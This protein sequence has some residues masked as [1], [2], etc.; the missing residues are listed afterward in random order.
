[1]TEVGRW[2]ASESPKTRDT[3][4]SFSVQH[5]NKG[6]DGESSRCGEGRGGTEGAHVGR[7]SRDSEDGH[8]AEGHLKAEH[9]GSTHGEKW[10][11]ASAEGRRRGPEVVRAA[12]CWGAVS[13]RACVCDLL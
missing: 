11:P 9:G 5:L 4:R 13:H 8:A 6:D 7:S 1:M 12:Q 2:R 10:G 3:Q